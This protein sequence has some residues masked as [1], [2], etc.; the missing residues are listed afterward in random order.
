MRRFSKNSL[1]K[2]FP[3]FFLFFLALLFL[4]IFKKEVVEVIVHGSTLCLS[5]IGIGG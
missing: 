2:L 5:C 1:R 4:G 3:A